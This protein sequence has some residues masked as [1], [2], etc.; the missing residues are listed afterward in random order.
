MTTSDHQTP[1]PFEDPLREAV[2]LAKR[3]NRRLSERVLP[4]ENGIPA[5]PRA[6]P[7]ADAAP[8]DAPPPGR[9]QA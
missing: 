4:P 9:T 7:A 5:P 2:E 3:I 1:T 8:D 6:E